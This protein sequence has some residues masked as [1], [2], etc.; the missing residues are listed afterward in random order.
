MNRVNDP[1]KLNILFYTDVHGHF[2]SEQDDSLQPGGLD[3]LVT[4]AKTIRQKGE[5]LLIIDNGDSIQ[6]THL[7]DLFNYNTPQCGKLKHP[8]SIVHEELGT[9]CFVLGN[10][11]FNFGLDHLTRIE[12]E[13]DIPWLSANIYKESTGE[14]FFQPYHIFEVGPYKIGILGLI[15]EFVPRWEDK[16]SIPDLEFR[17]VVE[18]TGRCIEEIRK[19]CDFLIVSYHGGLE[20]NPETG[21]PFSNHM[22]LENQGYALWKTFPEIDLLLAGHQHRQFSFFPNDHLRAPVIQAGSKGRTWAHIVLSG[23]EGISVGPENY[24]LSIDNIQFIDA[25][26]VPPDPDLKVKLEPYLKRIDEILNMHLGFVESNFLIEDPLQDVWINK[27][28]YI[29]WINELM[30]QAS[31][32][33]ISAISLLDPG[34]KGLPRKVR[35][36]DILENYHFLNTISVL[37]LSGKILKEALEKAATFFCIDTT[38][39]QPAIKVAPEWDTYKVRSY[40]YDMWHG[41]EYG[42]N[43]SKPIGQRLVWLK[44]K[45]KTIEDEDELKVV[46]TTYRAGGAFYNMFS[47]EQ[48]VMDFPAK[49]SDLMVNDILHR[50]HIHIDLHQNFK[51]LYDEQT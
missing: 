7:V 42:F 51:I 27:H 10:H 21:K 11:D 35:M 43:I 13:T 46:M 31:G 1:F 15:T 16:K 12:K 4:Y 17:S 6:G 3:R 40:D 44:Y 45:G 32:C 14:N 29:Q 38:G 50:K 8:I 26:T 5:K 20:K 18:E 19:Q 28:P 34:L 9:S 48:V 33:D 2:L 41:I 36:K 24:K 47:P 25:G 30:C 37:K 23:T 39:D 22:D 49:I